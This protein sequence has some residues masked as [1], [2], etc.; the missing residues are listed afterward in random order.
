MSL[1][2]AF[3]DHRQRCVGGIEVSPTADRL[4]NERG[5]LLRWWP[6]D[7][8]RERLEVLDDGGEMELV[9]RTR[10]PPKPHALEAMVGLQMREPHLDALSLVSRSGECLCLH[11]SPGDVAGVLVEVARDLAR[12]GIGAALRSDWAYIAVALRGTVE[13]RASVMYGATG[14]EQLAVRADIDTALPVPAEVRA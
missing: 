1:D 5:R 12:V 6:E 11:L 2:A 14:L 3:N 9:T 13:Q 4:R 10:K 7:S 8:K